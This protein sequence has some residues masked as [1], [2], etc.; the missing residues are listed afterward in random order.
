MTR[1]VKDQLNHFIDVSFPPIRIISLVPSQTELLYDLGLD[2]EIIGI[3]EYCVFPTHWARSKPI[4]GGTKDFDIEKIR[5]LQP[6][7]IIANKEENSRELIEKLQTMFP[8][9]ISDVVSLNN[10]LEMILAVGELTNRRDRAEIISKSI[11]IAFDSLDPLV[12]V[13]YTVLYLIW[14]KPWMGVASNTFIDCMLNKLGL[15]NS[16]KSAERYPKLSEADILNLN[17]DYI[18]LSS[19]PYP[20]KEKHVME[21]QQLCSSS[22]IILVDGKMFSWYGSH[23]MQS[24]TYFKSLKL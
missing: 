17:P 2:H 19:E 12:C 15:E 24:P 3:T 6:D 21:L 23:L 14:R 4:V 1:S 5:S 9:W 7:L 22:R 18:F 13:N 16:L 8:V 11:Q 20:F 10:A